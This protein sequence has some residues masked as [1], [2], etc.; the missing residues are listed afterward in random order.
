MR[1]LLRAKVDVNVIDEEGVTALT[2]AAMQG[3]LAIAK[4]LLEGKANVNL[5]KKGVGIT[6]MLMAAQ[7]KTPR[8]VTWRW[9]SCCLKPRQT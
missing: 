7:D 2:L 5:G 6:P 9:S 4:L 1:R 3:R 8:K